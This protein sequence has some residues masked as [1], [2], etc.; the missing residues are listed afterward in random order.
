MKKLL[1]IFV[2]LFLFYLFSV[3]SSTP[4]GWVYLTGVVAFFA[5]AFGVLVI[6][7]KIGNMA[8]PS[9]NPIKR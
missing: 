7:N 5:V 4:R 8:G 3:S 1:K 2:V 6:I 9:L